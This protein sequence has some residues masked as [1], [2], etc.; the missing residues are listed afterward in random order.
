MA[1]DPAILFYSADFLMQSSNLTM[2]ERGI[3]ITFL[4]LQHQIGHLDA[5]TISL[6]FNQ[7]QLTED[8]LKLLECDDD[9][10][11][12]SIWLDEIIAKRKAYSESRRTNR[13]GKTKNKDKTPDDS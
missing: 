2:E 13:R 9:G 3:Y 10:K 12:Y 7:N 5:K 11:L 1:K 6:Q 8:I 4:C